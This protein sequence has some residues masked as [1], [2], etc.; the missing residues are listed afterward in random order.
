VDMHLKG[1]EPFCLSSYDSA[2]LSS[3]GYVV[4]GSSAGKSDLLLRSLA[5]CCGA[6]RVCAYPALCRSALLAVSP[7]PMKE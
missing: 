7:R 3:P 5:R 1:S 6:V 2:D 4:Q